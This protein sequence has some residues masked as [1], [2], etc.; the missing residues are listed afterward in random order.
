[1]K[2]SKFL[3]TLLMATLFVGFTSC[4][5][6]DDEITLKLEKSVVDLQV[7]EK[8]IVKITEGNGDYRI[9]PTEDLI[10]TVEIIDSEIIIS[11]LSVG[12]KT[13]TISDKENKTATL[14]INVVGI[15]GT[16][17]MNE[18]KYSVEVDANEDVA[19]EIKTSLISNNFKTLELNVD[20][21][22]KMTTEGEEGEEDIVTGTYNYVD[23]I[24]TLAITEGETPETIVMNVIE[25]TKTSLKLNYDQTEDYQAKYPEG[26]VTKALVTF[27]LD[28]VASQE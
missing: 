9:A 21:T 10:A 5:D 7:G 20:K 24:L 22:F 18:E 28:V 19:E 27:E 8:A 3:L 26:E 11:G 6:D 13:I 25:A 15:T 12:S 16:W 23:K 14:T 1:M 17:Q 4:S 2:R